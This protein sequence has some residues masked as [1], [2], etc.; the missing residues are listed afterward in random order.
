VPVL[1][2]FIF[3]AA[4]VLFLLGLGYGLSL[5]LEEERSS[6][7]RWRLPREACYRRKT[8]RRRCEGESGC[9]F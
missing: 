6:T 4:V 9:V 8:R 2:F 1:L 7:R 3:I 5:L